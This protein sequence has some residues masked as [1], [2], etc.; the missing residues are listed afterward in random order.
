[1]GC[2]QAWSAHGDLWWTNLASYS[3]ADIDMLDLEVIYLWEGRVR[4]MEGMSTG[5]RKPV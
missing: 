3:S 2:V 1:M 4:G 5:G